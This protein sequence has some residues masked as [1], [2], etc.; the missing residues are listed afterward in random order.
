[1]C[2]GSPMSS[3]ALRDSCVCRFTNTC[4]PRD[5]ALKRSKRS[6]KNRSRSASTAPPPRGVRSRSLLCCTTAAS[7]F[8]IVSPK[9]TL[10]EAAPPRSNP[11]KKTNSSRRQA[12]RWGSVGDRPVAPTWPRPK[13]LGS[14]HKTV[15]WQRN[16]GYRVAL[17][18]S[19]LSL[20]TTF[21]SL[22]RVYP[23]ARQ[24]QQCRSVRHRCFACGS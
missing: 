12:E 13:G 9:T 24:S 22:R 8:S 15:A 1:M 7:T 2:V 5:T 16:S 10:F 11:S 3:D 21:A 20:T 17:A 14:W 23:N 18:N 4:A 19:L 6:P